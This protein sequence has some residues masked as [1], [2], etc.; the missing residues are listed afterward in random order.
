MHMDSVCLATI[1]PEAYEQK[2]TTIL[3]SVLCVKL[4]SFQR[5]CSTPRFIFINGINQTPHLF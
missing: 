5:P 4:A 2:S 1:K 3:C